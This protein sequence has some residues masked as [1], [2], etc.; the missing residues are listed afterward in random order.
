MRHMIICAMML[1]MALP[2]WAGTTDTE[3]RY[4]QGNHTAIT[5]VCKPSSLGRRV[6]PAQEHVCLLSLRALIKERKFSVARER[7]VA[8][9]GVRGSGDWHTALGLI[10][11]DSYYIEQ[12][13]SHAEAA[14]QAAAEQGH[15]SELLPLILYNQARAAQYTGHLSRARTLLSEVVQRSP[16]GFESDAARVMLAEDVYLSV[17]VGAF[18]ARENAIQLVRELQREGYSAYMRDATDGGRSIFRVRVGRL[19][20]YAAAKD[21][22]QE[23]GLRGYSTRI[24]P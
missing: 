24:T 4:L 16:W 17:Q 13:W 7:I 10:E 15:K 9:R 20:S 5:N 23:L 14:Y 8:L 21:L 11:G 22:Q 12:Q 1:L 18:E 2:A 6:T 19:S 3:T